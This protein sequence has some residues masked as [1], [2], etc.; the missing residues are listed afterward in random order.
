MTGI[1]HSV[2]ELLIFIYHRFKVNFIYHILTLVDKMFSNGI[3]SI[4][5]SALLLGL[6]LKLL[7]E[8]V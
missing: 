2:K 3:V 6:Y 4:V 5:F 8:L 1:K 7:L